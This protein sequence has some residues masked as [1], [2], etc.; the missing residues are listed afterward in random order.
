MSEA[1]THIV[2]HRDIVEDM[3]MSMRARPRDARGYPIP[4]FTPI[5][6]GKPDFRYV[7]EGK[8]QEALS[9][10]LCWTCGEPL[11]Q[12]TAYAFVVGPMCAVNRT[13]AEPPSH[14]VC[15]KYAA[16]ACPFLA[17]PKLERKSEATPEQRDK[18]PGIMLDRNPGVA[19]VWVT[20]TGSYSTAVKLF[21]LGEPMR[22]FWYAHSREATREEVLESIG[23]GM[24]F[25]ADLAAQDGPDAVAELQR[26]V[27][28]LKPLLPAT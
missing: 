28:A 21:D 13:S 20:S 9:R 23:S 2:R 19:L 1:D 17:R 10:G 12:L 8:A 16:K 3:P 27:V 14:I 15:A 24:P 18:V 4:W 25:L 6:N 5:V 11:S 22:T 26:R 7:V